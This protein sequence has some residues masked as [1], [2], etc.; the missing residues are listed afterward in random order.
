MQRGIKEDLFLFQVLLPLVNIPMID[1]TLE[2]LASAGVEEV[3]VFCCAHA[4]QITSYLDNS[5]WHS[6]PKFKV[7]PIESHDCVSVGEALRVIDQRN[8]V[9]SGI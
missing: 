3:F 9:C 8:V 6:Q 7:V 2:W 5:A 4:K 1:Y